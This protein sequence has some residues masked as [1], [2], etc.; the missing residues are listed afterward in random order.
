MY[1]AVGCHPWLVSALGMRSLA[2]LYS[3]AMSA[4][5]TD[6]VLHGEPIN[7]EHRSFSSVKL[8]DMQ[9]ARGKK[10]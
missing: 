1:E 7:A 2:P 10:G 4:M 9:L 8:D 3:S 6:R 5:R